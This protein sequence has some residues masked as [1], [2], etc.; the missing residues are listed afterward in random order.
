[1]IGKNKT[2]VAMATDL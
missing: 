2:N 1:M